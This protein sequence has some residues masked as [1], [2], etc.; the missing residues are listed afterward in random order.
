MR[1][2]I[3]ID[4]TITTA[5]YWLDYFNAHLGTTLKP[6]DVLHYDHHIDFNISLEAFK[7]FRM[8]HL[9]EIHRL[10][11]ARPSAVSVLN[12]LVKHGNETFLI[13]AREKSLTLLT[14]SWLK[15]NQISHT[16]LYHL[17]TTDKVALAKS[18]CIELFLEDRYETA[19]AM[20]NAGIPTILFST[21]YNKAPE[22]PLIVRID[23]W[24]EAQALIYKLTLEELGL[25]KSNI[26][27]IGLSFPIE[28]F[29]SDHQVNG[30]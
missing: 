27:E 22:H 11:I 16:K 10:A 17:G 14:N 26:S 5:Y 12:G 25:S 9:L 1:I 28:N 3:D 4:G 19:L 24:L 21:S 6:E 7:T 15:D 29:S 20:A 30:Y 13:T 8:D 18:K 23:D 2:G